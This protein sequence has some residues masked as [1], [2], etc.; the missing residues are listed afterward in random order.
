MQGGS[1][2]GT[3]ENAVQSIN[4]DQY[5]M[6]GH[7][8]AGMMRGKRRDFLSSPGAGIVP[9]RPCDPRSVA[10]PT[11]PPLNSGTLRTCRGPGYYSNHLVI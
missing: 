2:R 3:T 11:R 1:Q 6:T 10:I 8:T 9:K 5:V 4:Y 7:G